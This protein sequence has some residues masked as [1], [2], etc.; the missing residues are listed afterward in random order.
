M[1]PFKCVGPGALCDLV[2]RIHPSCFLNPGSGGAQQL[3]LICLLADGWTE[4]QAVHARP[5]YGLHAAQM[6][7]WTAAFYQS[8]LKEK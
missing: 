2:M 5:L 6:H 3:G 4:S 1:E 8:Q 7:I